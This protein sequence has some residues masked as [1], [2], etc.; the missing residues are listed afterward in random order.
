MATLTGKMLGKYLLSER[1]G[2]GGM[3]EVYKAFH[4]KLQRTMTIKVL[5]SYLME[6]ENFQARFEREARALAALRHPH[7]VQIHDFDVQD[8]LY[9]M[10]M[11]YIDG[12]NLQTRMAELSK[13]SAY[14]PVGQVAGITRQVAEAL[15]YAHR[16]GVLH[17]DIKPSN[18]MLDTT[19]NAYLTDF[20]IARIMGESQF[21]ATGDLIGTPAYMS[22][23][24]GKGLELTNASDIYSLGV[25]LYEM[26]TGK[27]PFYSDTPLAVIH[28]QISDPIPAPSALRPGIPRELDEIVKRSLDK[29]P[30]KRYQTAGELS[31]ALDKVITPQ[32]SS[33]LD[34]GTSGKNLPVSAMPTMLVPEEQ[35]TGSGELPIDIKTAATLVEPSQSQGKVEPAMTNEKKPVAPPAAT[36]KPKQAGQRSPDAQ[37][38][39]RLII[40]ISVVVGLVLLG[41]F[42]CVINFILVNLPNVNVT[43]CN[44]IDT[45]VTKANELRG[46]GDLNGFI[47]Y[48]DMAVSMVPGDQHPPYAGLW[49][50]LGDAKLSLGLNDMA[51]ESYQN[52]IEWTNNDPDLQYIRSRAVEGLNRTP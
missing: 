2:K 50:D 34:K 41:I 27:T 42:A 30:K 48:M 43:S 39:R 14:M 24:Q 4:P 28:K 44:S 35:K 49:C 17:R 38:N 3:A 15:D 22:P 13:A 46:K 20:G 25:V 37:R 47:N 33:R 51:R 19:G 52:C 32:L 5:H 36:P 12:G 1:L 18:I 45:C 16:Q 7:I 29:D 21:T 23:E 10:V 31:G 8:D 6:G 11:E 40:G 9:Y 26:L